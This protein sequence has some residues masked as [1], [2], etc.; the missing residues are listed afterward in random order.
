[1]VLARLLPRGVVVIA[2]V[3]TAIV[4]DFTDGFHDT[5]NA[6]ATRSPPVLRP[7]VTVTITECSTSSTR[8]RL[9]PQGLR[10]ANG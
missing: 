4:F 5:A 10:P 1:M 9:L 8:S 3:V 7:K 6:M 2:V